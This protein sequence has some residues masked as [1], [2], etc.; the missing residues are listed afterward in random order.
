[1]V[2]DPQAI[3][4]EEPSWWWNPLSY[5]TDEVRAARLADHFASGTRGP[6]AQTDAYF[7]PAGQDLLA[8]A[9]GR[10][11][12]HPGSHL[13]D[14]PH[15]RRRRPDPDGGRLL[16]RPATPSEVSSTYTTN[17]AA[18]FTAPLCRWPP[19]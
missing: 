8:A 4:M 10:P 7:D 14:R 12:H 2:F 9:P 16:P 5:V 13:A 11:S 1:M 17:N 3:A 18:A 15:R 6:G 19:A